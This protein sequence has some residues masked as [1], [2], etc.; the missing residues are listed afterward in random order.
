MTQKVNVSSAIGLFKASKINYTTLSQND[1]W[2]DLKDAK[3]SIGIIIE[4]PADATGSYKLECISADATIDSKSIPLVSG[5]V[6]LIYITSF[7]LKDNT[8]IANFSIVAS[9]GSSINSLGFKA[10]VIKHIPVMNH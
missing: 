9:D 7:G 2:A 6:N 4:I 3:E 1:F 8:G 5:V 10:A